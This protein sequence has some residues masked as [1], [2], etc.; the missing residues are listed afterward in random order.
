[1]NKGEG[2]ADGP[3]V[4]PAADDVPVLDI[5]DELESFDS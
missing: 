1:M 2:L 5:D 3:S 4:D